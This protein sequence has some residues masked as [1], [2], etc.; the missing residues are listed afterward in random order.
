VCVDRPDFH[1]IQTYTVVEG[2]VSGR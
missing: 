1:H 2:R